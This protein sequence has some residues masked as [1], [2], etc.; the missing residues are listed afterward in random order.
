MTTSAA[1]RPPRLSGISQVSMRV[2]DLPRAVSFYRDALGLSLLSEHEEMAFLLAGS[3]RIM[4][5]LQGS[6]QAHQSSS[7]LYF[8][9]R[10]IDADCAALEALGVQLLRNPFVAHTE[11]G[12]QFW[13][14]YFLDSEGNTLGL[15]QWRRTP[16]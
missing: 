2:L 8:D 10:D 13:L 7:V 15:S 5:A 9:S 14:A 3:V 4:L 1:T 11:G 6:S 16:A 12:H